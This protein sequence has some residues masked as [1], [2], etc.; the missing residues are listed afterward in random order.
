MFKINMTM[1]MVVVVVVIVIVMMKT[2][3][4]QCLTKL[5]ARQSKILTD[6]DPFLDTLCSRDCKRVGALH[7]LLHMLHHQPVMDRL[8]EG[9]RER[10]REG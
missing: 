5:A 9:E 7:C 3:T 8:R 10:G 6:K 2:I 1:M 4:K